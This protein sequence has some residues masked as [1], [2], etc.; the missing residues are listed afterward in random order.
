[1]ASAAVTPGHAFTKKMDKAGDSCRVH[2]ICFV[3]FVVE[4]LG[5]FHS[6]ADR[7]VRKLGAA[8]AR[9]NGQ[10]EEEASR[11]L[12]QRLSIMIQ[13]GN[14]SMITNRK[15]NYPSPETDGDL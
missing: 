3:P 4:A 9:H 1:M 5:G 8:L 7:Q 15:S 10:Q 13:K 11:H 12:F 14:S 2:G 6:A